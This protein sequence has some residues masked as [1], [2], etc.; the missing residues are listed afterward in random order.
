MEPSVLSV[1]EGSSIDVTFRLSTY[2][3]DT[4][5][6]EFQLPSDEI[7]IQGNSVLT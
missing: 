5:R 7:T 4:L 3:E 2:V 6:V 1:T